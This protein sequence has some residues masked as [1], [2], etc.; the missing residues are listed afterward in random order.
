[1]VHDL[2]EVSHVPIS[3]LGESSSSTRRAGLDAVQE[4][5][6][7]DGEAG[8]PVAVLREGNVGGEVEDS[9]GL[10]R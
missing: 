9:V 6:E 2:D 10:A 1:M 5:G 3:S 8:V 4:P 7:A